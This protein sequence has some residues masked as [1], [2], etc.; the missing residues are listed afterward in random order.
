M[1][2]KQTRLFVIVDPTAEHQMG[3]VK[4]LLIAK[5]GDCHLHACLCVYEDIEQAGPYASRKEFKRHMLAQADARLEQWLQPCKL[6]DVSYSSE[7]IWNSNWVEGLVRAVQKSNCDL[8]IKSSYQH[9]PARRF[10]S[11]TSDF[12]LMRHCACPILFT[13]QAQEWQSDRILACLDLAA[14]DPRHARLNHDIM[15]NALAFADIVGM[16]LYIACAFQGVLGGAQ[17]GLAAHRDGITP[18]Q[19]GEYYGLAA[20]RVILRQGDTVEALRGVCSEIDPGIVFIGSLART[21]IKGKLIGNTA[22]KL[23]DIV[24]GDLLVVN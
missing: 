21:G 8:V 13:H 17:L 6:S 3:L 14:D 22:E 16:D 11:T 24:S 1:K 23:L 10:F 5:L 12:Y 4:A 9:S 20:D 2:Q 18:A 19:V 7:V 15:R